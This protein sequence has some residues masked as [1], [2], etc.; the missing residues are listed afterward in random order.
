MIEHAHTLQVTEKQKIE[1]AK[2]LYL[3]ENKHVHISCIAYDQELRK[4]YWD[5]KALRRYLEDG[6]KEIESVVER[7]L[8]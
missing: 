3:L 8:A 2:Y 4:F 5:R 1:A 7:M 6:N